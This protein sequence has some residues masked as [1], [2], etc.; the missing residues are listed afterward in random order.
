M[1]NMMDERA[2]QLYVDALATSF[3]RKGRS[4]FES[5]ISAEN[6]IAKQFSNQ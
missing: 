4:S 5:K 1:T 6:M 3:M 2:Y